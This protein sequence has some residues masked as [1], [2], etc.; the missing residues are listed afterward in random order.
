MITVLNHLQK[1]YSETLIEYLFSRYTIFNIGLK[2]MK[3]NKFKIIINML[4]I[5]MS[6]LLQSCAS[7]YIPTGK[8]AN[9]SI[10]NPQFYNN[11]LHIEVSQDKYH[12]ETF[13]TLFSSGSKDSNLLNTKIS[14]DKEMYFKILIHVPDDSRYCDGKLSFNP[15][16]GKN[17]RLIADMSLVVKLCRYQLINTTDNEP[18]KLNR[19]D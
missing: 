19:W 6:L 1:Y 2:K 3:Y 13:K 18:L 4:P 8:T 17:Y 7:K 11:E 12:P 9:L 14:A 10:D 15:I 16:A 5:I